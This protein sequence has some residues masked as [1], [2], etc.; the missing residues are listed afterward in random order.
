[1]FK[2]FT[3]ITLIASACLLVSPILSLAQEARCGI[4]DSM[5]MPLEAGIVDGYDD[6]ARYRARFG[7][8]HT[9][10]DIGFDYWGEPVFAAARGG[11][12]YA[13]PEGWDN[14]EGVVI[15]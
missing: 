15:V 11:V 10:L 8:N 2:G 12:T 1:M 13:D 5:G 6:F 3:V 14:E 9:G 7:G 4:V